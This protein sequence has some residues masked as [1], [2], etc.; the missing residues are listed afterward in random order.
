MKQEDGNLKGARTAGANGD[1]SQAAVF[2]GP[3]CCFS[4]F[5]FKGKQ[6]K[7]LGF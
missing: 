3:C 2:Y 6:I 4:P 5:F 1:Q 7:G